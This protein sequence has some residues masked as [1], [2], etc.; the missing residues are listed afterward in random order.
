MVGTKNFKPAEFACPCGCNTNEMQQA[1]VEILQRIRDNVGSSMPITSGYRC[2]KHNSEVGGKKNSAHTRGW[3][4]D[5]GI[6]KGDSSKRFKIIAY[7]L[8]EGV[9]RIGIGDS[10]I[11]LDCDPDLPYGQIWLY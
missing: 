4:V 2:P 9:R 5:I 6:K 3:A 7:A 1:F 10:F 11:H 8:Q